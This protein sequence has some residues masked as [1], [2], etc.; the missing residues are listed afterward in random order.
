MNISSH[1]TLN[2]LL[3]YYTSLPHPSLYWNFCSVFIVY[4]YGGNIMVIKLFQKSKIIIDNSCCFHILKGEIVLEV[5]ECLLK[6]H[7]VIVHVLSEFGRAL[8]KNRTS[9]F[10]SP[11]RNPYCSLQSEYIRFCKILRKLSAVT[12]RS[13]P[14]LVWL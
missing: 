7:K 13:I 3:Q 1:C 8:M 5:V 6:V 10:S 11:L 2:I 4:F 14:F 9:R 12:F